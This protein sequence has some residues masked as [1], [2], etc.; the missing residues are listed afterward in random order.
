MSI[1]SS[2]Q[3]DIL[4]NGHSLASIV[5]LIV[6]VLYCLILAFI[7]Y[8]NS[9][10]YSYL[11]I[12]ITT[13]TTVPIDNNIILNFSGRPTHENSMNTRKIHLSDL[14]H[15]ILPLHYYFLLYIN[16]NYSSDQIQNQS[17]LRIAGRNL[18]A[19]SSPTIPSQYG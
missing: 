15:L 11:Y 14:F 17:L 12:A 8:R 19:K 6:L 18:Q 16:E 13:I 10:S 1:Q 4:F 2:I 7:E 9:L 5:L 3:T